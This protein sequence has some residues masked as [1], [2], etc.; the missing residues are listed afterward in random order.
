MMSNEK[1]LTN[2]MQDVALTLTGSQ[3]YSKCIFIFPFMFI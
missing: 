3:C 2:Q 1:D